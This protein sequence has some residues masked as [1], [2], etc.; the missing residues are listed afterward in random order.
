[1]IINTKK[2]RDKMNIRNFFPEKFFGKTLFKN[3]PLPL[4]EN[5][6]RERPILKDPNFPGKFDGSNSPPPLSRSGEGVT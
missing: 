1:L 5:V 4:R 3:T 6:Y 2:Q